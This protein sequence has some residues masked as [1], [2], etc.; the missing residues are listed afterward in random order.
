M[1]EGQMGH[2]GHS[3]HLEEKLFMFSSYLSVAFSSNFDTFMRCSRLSG[4]EVQFLQ[5]GE[6]LKISLTSSVVKGSISLLLYPTV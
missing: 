1:T 5:H 6:G 4:G 2:T 3:G